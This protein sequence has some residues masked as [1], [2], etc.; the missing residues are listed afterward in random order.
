MLLPMLE[1]VAHSNL[2]WMPAHTTAKHVGVRR[3]GDGQLLAAIDRATNAIA[4]EHAKIAVAEHRVPEAV[5]EHQNQRAKI[6]DEVAT[7][8]GH[9][10]F[11]A[12]NQPSHPKRDTAAARP[13]K[14]K[15]TARRSEARNVRSYGQRTSEGTL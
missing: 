3:K 10:T 12:N 8:I 4:D 1:G 15:G 5:R 6:I 14:K 9:A 7:W 2:T 11:S 13:K